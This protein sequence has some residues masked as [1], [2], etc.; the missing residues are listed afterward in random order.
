[1]VEMLYQYYVLHRRTIG[2]KTPRVLSLTLLALY[3][4]M[5][6][7]VSVVCP[8]DRQRQRRAAGLL[9]SSGA[10]ICGR[11]VPA[12]DRYLQQ[13]PALSSKYR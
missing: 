1:M 12:V 8:V 9:L 4:S 10:C 3:A 6:L 5:Q 11:R 13:A 7:S 2:L